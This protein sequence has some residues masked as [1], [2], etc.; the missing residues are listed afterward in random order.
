[1]V[2][3]QKLEAELFQIKEQHQE[4]KTFL[5]GKDSFNNERKRLYS[6]KMEVNMEK[7]AAEITLVEEQAHKRQEEKE[8]GG[9]R[10]S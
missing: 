1:M 6:L 10:A 4:K 5:E 9:S 2:R 3:P 8:G 7:V